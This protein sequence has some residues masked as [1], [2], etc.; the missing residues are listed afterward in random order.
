VVVVFGAPVI[1]SGTPTFAG[2]TLLPD[3]SHQLTFAW[4]YA[5]QGPDWQSLPDGTTALSAMSYITTAY[6]MGGQAALGVTA[7]LGII[8]LAW[9]YQPLLTV[10]AVAGA[11]ALAALMEPWVR[12]ARTR[13]LIAFVAIQSSLVVG[14]ALQGSIKELASMAMLLTAVALLARALHERRPA[15]SLLVV[16]VPGAAML[17]SLGPAALPYLA[18]VALVAVAAVLVRVVRERRAMELA[19]LGAGAVVAAVLALPVLLDLVTALRAQT[20]TLDTATAGAKPTAELGHLARPI[21][22]GQALGVWLEGDYRI[23]PDQLTLQRVISALIAL[24]VVVGGL[25]M[26]R[27]RA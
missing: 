14:F 10:L 17:V 16:A 15:R 7:P 9:L 8:D 27:R 5:L 19:W 20:G 23:L 12:G 21:D 6:P 25:W 26:L 24:A 4:L 2:Y 11:L 3:T 1:L 22:P 18:P 13:A